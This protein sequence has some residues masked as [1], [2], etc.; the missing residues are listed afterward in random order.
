MSVHDQ[1]Y[2]FVDVTGKCFESYQQMGK[3]DCDRKY[4]DHVGAMLRASHN[5]EHPFYV[6]DMIIFKEEL[7]DA[8]FRWGRDFYV[9]KVE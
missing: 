5:D 4:H 2:K 9:K 8:G 7:I 3:S 6:G 1:Q